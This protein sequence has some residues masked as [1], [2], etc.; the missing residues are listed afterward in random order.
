MTQEC[1]LRSVSVNPV[2]C[3]GCGTCAA[4]APEIFEMDPLTEKAVVTCD[5]CPE[6]AALLARAYCPH[7]C[8]EV[9]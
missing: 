4:M 1:P 7:D 2:C 8:I 6:D 9:D 5:E 3:N